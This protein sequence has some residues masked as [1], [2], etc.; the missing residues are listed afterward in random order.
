M[1]ARSVA[2]LAGLALFAGTSHAR[3]YSIQPTQTLE[4]ANPDGVFGPPKVAIDG[5]AAIAL[6]D[7]ATGREAVLLQRNASG[8]WA[9]VR[10]LLSVPTSSRLQNELD[11]RDGK[12]V[13]LLDDFLHIF[14]RGA[15]GAWAE[16]A[17]AG[18]PRA[19]GGV[20]ISG[21]RVV[22]GRIGSSFDAN[23]FQKSVGT[24][25]WRVTGRISA[26][27]APF[28]GLGTQV[29]VSGDVAVILAGNKVSVFRWNNAF[30]WEQMFA[31]QPPESLGDA[32]PTLSDRTLIFDYGYVW[33]I[34]QFDYSWWSRRQG[35]APIDSGNGATGGFGPN[36][37]DGFAVAHTAH[38]HPRDD[39]HPYVYLQSANLAHHAILLTP[40]YSTQSDISGRTVVS[41]SQ[42]FGGERYVSF[43]D[44]PASAAPPA[45]VNDFS[46]SDIAAFA[47]TPGS[48][49]AHATAGANGLFR[50]SS[51]AGDA[52]ASV[53]AVDWAVEQA[54]EADITPTAV[55]GADRWVGLAV[56]Y[57]DTNNH[58][59]VTLRS[60]GVIELKRKVAGAY[61][62]LA[63]AALPFSIGARRHVQLVV[64]GSRLT[65]NVDGTQR[66][67]ATDD[68]LT[69]GSVALLTYRARADF[70]NVYASPT[71]PLDL[72]TKDLTQVSSTEPPFWQSGGSWTPV[73]GPG[74]EIIGRAQ[75]STDGDVAAITG[76]ATDDQVVSTRVRLD[77]YGA[78]G[79]GAWFG[80]FARWNEY[81]T[82]YYLTV[83]STGRLEIRRRL[84]G[85][86]IATLASVP[87]TA[88]PGRFYDLKFSVRGDQLQAYVDGVLVADAHDSWIPQGR[89]GLGM[90][91][92]AATFS[93]FEAVQ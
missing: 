21:S 86:E 40:G 5:D 10:T 82:Y 43:F 51:L 22:A 55:D 65:V 60:S 12:A 34:D 35:L 3:V 6:L 47:Q 92:A 73:E 85:Q 75:T 44:V 19:I 89:C 14:E 29:D 33:S 50:Q 39:A 25:I 54:V 74:G 63:S 52:Q 28:A 18:T 64:H 36:M 41:S 80:L 81:D 7:T 67:V 87:F 53:P 83:R 71:A 79:T 15:N 32:P 20:S 69:H 38:S 2:L 11:M 17:T 78:S 76:S 48:Q 84:D 62:T 26:G 49:F 58:Y 91:R 68:A 4:F 57:A 42:G 70:D 24:G 88:Q 46:S 93:R 59:Y 8:Q 90:Y 72:V 37:R 23:V 27:P 1:N 45:Y 56:R 16:S 9:L 66:L 13:I 31:Y 30:D 61:A 77:A